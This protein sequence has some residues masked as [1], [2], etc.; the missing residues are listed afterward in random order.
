MNWYEN[1]NLLIWLIFVLCCYILYKIYSF[2]TQDDDRRL[3]RKEAFCIS[4]ITKKERKY[5][6]PAFFFK[7][8]LRTNRE[9][10]W[11]YQNVC[12]KKRC[13]VAFIYSWTFKRGF[14][15]VEKAWEGLSL[16]EVLKKIN[17]RFFYVL[18]TCRS[19]STLLFL[20]FFDF[21]FSSAHES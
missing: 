5:C 15:N 13:H 12:K 19:I 2:E 4:L 20:W 8:C 9:S 17:R 10:M 21:A 11:P 6:P 14:Q 7:F 3:D 1:F 16:K 18:Y